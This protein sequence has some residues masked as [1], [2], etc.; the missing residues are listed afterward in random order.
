MFVGIIE[1][2]LANGYTEIVTVTD[3]PFERILARIG[4]PVQRLTEPKKIGVAMA[5]ASIL[6][7]HADTFLRLRPTNYRKEETP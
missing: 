6:P 4:W 7:A 3:L 1:W 5:V 2:G